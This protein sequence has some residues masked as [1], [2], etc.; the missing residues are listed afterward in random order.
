MT[1]A[2]TEHLQSGDSPTDSSAD[3]GEPLGQ[4]VANLHAASEQLADC[5]RSLVEIEGAVGQWLTAAVHKERREAFERAR[6]SLTQLWM[7]EVTR[8]GRDVAELPS[9]SDSRT[10]E[11][12]AGR[13]ADLW[14]RYHEHELAKPLH[15]EAT[16]LYD[17]RL[18]S[19]E[20]LRTCAVRLE[21]M[22]G[23]NAPLAI[24]AVLAQPQEG[25]RARVGHY[26]A[27]IGQLLAMRWGPARLFPLLFWAT[28]VIALL[29]SLSGMVFRAL[30]SLTVAYMVFVFAPPLLTRS[31][32]WPAFSPRW[33]L[34]PIRPWSTALTA[35]EARGSLELIEAR[36]RCALA[37][38][39]GLNLRA[40]HARTSYGLLIART[41]RG[42]GPTS[43]EGTHD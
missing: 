10:V 40:E 17:S 27:A 9:E 39:E 28:V 2:S 8:L 1:S 15:G 25:L 14:W 29:F 35:D 13:A 32:R 6:S 23:P 36:T 43:V 38:Y 42:P 7:D 22:R 26:R 33:L 4:L 12:L 18:A 30:V 11:G 24:E 20:R 37:Y 5:A 31:R 19:W 21:R 3:A 34:L 16:A 41:A